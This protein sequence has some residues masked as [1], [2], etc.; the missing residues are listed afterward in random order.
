MSSKF[1]KSVNCLALALIAV[2]ATG[3]AYKKSLV[4]PP[5]VSYSENSSVIE[6][7]IKKKSPLQRVWATHFDESSG[8]VTTMASIAVLYWLVKGNFDKA[9]KANCVAQTGTAC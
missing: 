6:F 5:P 8:M 7:E 9:E 4:V 2:L 3:C 1:R